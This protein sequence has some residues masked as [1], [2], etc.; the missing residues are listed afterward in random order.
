MSKRDQF[1]TLLAELIEA[2]RDEQSHIDCGWDDKERQQIEVRLAKARKAMA[3]F[4]EKI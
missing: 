3:K 2:E 4:A 1:N